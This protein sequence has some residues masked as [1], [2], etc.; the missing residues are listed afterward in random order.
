MKI[1]N[2]LKEFYE[3]MAK[4][5]NKMQNKMNDLNDD[6]RSGNVSQE[7]ILKGMKELE[8]MDEEY[9]EGFL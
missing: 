3:S 2:L 6:I 9:Y 4:S 1:N 7:D 5:P 8:G